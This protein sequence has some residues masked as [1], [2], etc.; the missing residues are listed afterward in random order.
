[1]YPAEENPRFLTPVLIVAM[2]QGLLLW[3]VISSG[4]AAGWPGNDMVW[5]GTLLPFGVLIA[6]LLY[7]LAPWAGRRRAWFIVASIAALLLAA[8]RQHAA[9]A[10]A[11]GGTAWSTDPA[12]PPYVLIQV[13]LLFHAVPFLQGYLRTGRWRPSY[14]SLFLDAWQNALRL[15]LAAVFTIVFMLLLWLCAQLF[16]MIGLPFIRVLLDDVAG[17]PPLLACPAFGIGF[18]LVGSAERLLAALRQQ[19]LALLKWLL[20]IATLVLVAFSLALALRA[21]ALWAEQQHVIRAV[22]LLWLAIVTV[23]LYNAAY[24]DGSIDS[25]YPPLLGRLLAWSAPLLLL[26]SGMAAYDLWIRI[27]A[28]GLTE[29]RY[30]AA[31]VAIVTLAYSLGYAI[32]GVRAG[33]WMNAVGRTNIG[34]ALALIALLCGSLLPLTCPDR[35]VARSQALRLAQSDGSA[36]PEDFMR[37]RFDLG[38]YGYDEL[39]RLAG[40]AHTAAGIRTG[41][42]LALAVDNG[43]DRYQFRYTTVPSVRTTLAGFP[44]NTT[45]D[46]D[47][48]ARIIALLPNAPVRHRA[49]QRAASPASMHIDNNAGDATTADI[50]T[51]TIP[52]PVLFVD[53]DGDGQ[54]EALAFLPDE[55]AVFQRGEHGWNKLGQT[56]WRHRA[57]P[58]HRRTGAELLQLLRGG[59]YKVVEPRWKALQFGAG[60]L[61]L[62][63]PERAEPAGRG[64]TRTD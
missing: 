41:A 10:A 21:P 24:Q 29:A 38:G 52:C 8:N 49:G 45:I 7:G 32:A 39:H 6:P 44:A 18:L 56:D 36:G 37:L 47:L 53:L 58:P 16:D 43:R 60:R 62:W 42:R 11:P 59:D 15:A 12:S 55:A 5:R 48:S 63:L 30:W 64:R 19:V 57:Q 50:C 17:F 61:D 35:L 25:P 46:A 34:V 54:P 20:P 40:D 9:H 1:M 27:D 13:L 3:W 26:L 28:Y 4:D 51:D 31:L 2:L 33:R 14:P 23:Y 22:W